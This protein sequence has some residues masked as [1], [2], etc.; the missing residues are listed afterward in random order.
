MAILVIACKDAADKKT[1]AIAITQ[2]VKKPKFE[3]N[4]ESIKANYKDPEWFNKTKFGIFIHW[5]AY[6]VPAY[7]SEWY[8]RQMY[9]DTANFNAQLNTGKAGP[10]QEYLHHKKNW[11][12]QK[13]FG[14]KDFIPMFKGENFDA[15]EWIDLFKKAGAKYVIP[16]ADHHD[17]FAMY[18]SN[19]TRWNAYDMGP[20]RDILGELFKAGRSKGMIMGASSH[21]AFNWSF[22]NKKDHFDTTDP[23]Y[24]DLYSSKGKDLT[25][26]VSEEFKQRWW[27]RTT[28]LID[29]YQPDILWFD[30]YLDIPDYADQRPKLAAY[31]YNKGVEWGKEVVLQDKNFSHEAFPEGTVVY[32][33]ER[34]KLPGIRKL[35]WQTDT[36]IGKNSWS[37]VT[38]WKSKT[39]NQIVDDLVDIVSKNGCLLLNVGPKSDGTIPEDQKEILLQI[40]SWLNINGEAIYDTKYWDTFG[41]GPTEV[42]KGHH[43]EGDN[44]GL[45]SKDIRFTSKGNKLY[46]IVLDWPKDGNVNITT[47]AKNSEYAKN[48]K[49]SNISVLGSSEKIV[50]SQTDE[51][52]VVKMPKEKPC[53]YAYTIEITL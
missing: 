27:D 30:F 2:K 1:E 11:G 13:T 29:N 52:L 38:N 9:M 44:Q 51:G 28:D 40:G 19:T 4:W 50:W 45:S 36:S 42:K 47:L 20:K 7:G 31:Y 18:K 14:Y 15:N 5:G 53:D 26:P 17:G 35:P 49:I 12:D 6:T 8:P 22:Y 24:A 3:A 32:D 43:S 48:I 33:L 39:A 34:G 23:Q 37:Y 21:F 41:E 25:E 10:S 16:V 46:A